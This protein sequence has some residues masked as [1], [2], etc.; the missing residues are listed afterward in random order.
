MMDK[1]LIKNINYL[2]F[3]QRRPLRTLKA[4]QFS[5]DAP[6]KDFGDHPQDTILKDFV[7]NFVFAKWMTFSV[8]NNNGDVIRTSRI[9]TP[10]ETTWLFFSYKTLE[11]M[12]QLLTDLYGNKDF[13]Y[14]ISTMKLINSIFAHLRENGNDP[15]DNKLKAM[16]D[17]R[18]AMKE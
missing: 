16:E 7:N 15:L 8:L 1:Q 9:L 18:D 10:T 2:K 6:K 3:F 11:E 14:A 4:Y 17:V 13:S 12:H 5:Y